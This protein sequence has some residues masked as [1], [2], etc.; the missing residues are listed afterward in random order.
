M[1]GSSPRMWGTLCR[2]LPNVR[3]VRFIPTHVGNSSRSDSLRGPSAVHPHACGELILYQSRMTNADGSSPRM[4][5]THLRLVGQRDI[6]RFIPTHVG[7]S[8]RSSAPR[9]PTSVHPHACGELPDTYV[10]NVQPFGSSPRM[11]GTR[12]PAGPDRL[13]RRFIPTHV[14][15]SCGETR[16][17]THGTVHPHACGELGPSA[18][19]RR[20]LIGSSPRMWGTLFILL[21]RERKVLLSTSR[22]LPHVGSPSRTSMGACLR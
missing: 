9:R 6:P 2:K 8:K 19:C 5:G 16:G 13:P 1:F 17:P 20:G 3:D 4:W 15:N 10:R 12:G 22:I 21:L 18:P 11:W 7:N 14:G